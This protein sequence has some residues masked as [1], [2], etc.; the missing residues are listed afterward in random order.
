M[1]SYR[2]LPA[3]LTALLL[4]FFI[5]GIAQVSGTVIAVEDGKPV[6]GVSILIKG[7]NRGTTSAANGSY[8]IDIKPGDQILQFSSVGFVTQEVSIQGRTKIDVV[9]EADVK[10]LED[11]VVVGYGTVKKSDLTGSVA[12]LKGKDLTSVP[13]SNPMQALQGKV[14]GVQVANFSGA[15]GAGSYVRIRG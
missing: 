15:P 6:P 12:S 3:S 13:A 2:L 7:T 10:T 8:V 9:L 5:H 11:V 14:A 1:K 4:F